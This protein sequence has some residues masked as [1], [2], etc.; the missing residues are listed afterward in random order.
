MKKPRIDAVAQKCSIKM[1]F[2]KNFRNFT[3]KHQRWVFLVKF[4]RTL[5]CSCF[6]WNKFTFCNYHASY[7]NKVRK[8]T[9]QVAGFRKSFH[10]DPKEKLIQP[11]PQ[12]DVQKYVMSTNSGKNTLSQ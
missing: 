2:G 12:Y 10:I 6:C 7:L 9:T 3:R 4:Q 8:N 5:A 11:E 1:L